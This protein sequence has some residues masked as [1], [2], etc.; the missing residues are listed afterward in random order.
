MNSVNKIS[1]SLEKVLIEK[2][3]IRKLKGYKKR[4]SEIEKI[5][6]NKKLELKREYKNKKLPYWAKSNFIKGKELKFFKNLEALI[7][8]SYYIVPQVHMSHILET[9]NKFPGHKYNFDFTR[10]NSLSLDFVLFNK[11]DFTFKLAIEL[12][13]SSHDALDRIERDALVETIMKNSDMKLVRMSS[14]D[15]EKVLFYL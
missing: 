7:G 12:D 15:V 8:D 9:R 1:S 6:E 13:D 2:K 5:R 3:P 10:I 4:E 14:F 11:S